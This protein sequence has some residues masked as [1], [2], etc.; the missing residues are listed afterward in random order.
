MEEVGRIRMCIGAY[1]RAMKF[2]T[3]M[4]RCEEGPIRKECWKKWAEKRGL[5][6]GMGND[7]KEFLETFGWTKD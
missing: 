2:N 1:G 3:K 5:E 6:S 7:R 4:A